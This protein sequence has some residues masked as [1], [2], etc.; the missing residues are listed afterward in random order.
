MWPINRLGQ[1]FR[2]TGGETGRTIFIRAEAAERDPGQPIGGTQFAHQI[3]TV[4]VGQADVA[5]DDIE[6]LCA[7]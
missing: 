6:L 5:D 3:K 2:K 4:A 1:V 7:D